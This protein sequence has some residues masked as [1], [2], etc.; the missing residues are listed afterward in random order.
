MNDRRRINIALSLNHKYM[1]YA[2][3]MLT[4]L[5]EN[6]PNSLKLYIYFLYSDLTKEDKLKLEDV[7]KSHGGEAYWLSV[8]VELFLSNL[9]ISTGWSLEIYYRLLLADILPEEI[10]RILYLDVDIIINHSLENLFFTDLEGKLLGA[11]ADV[12]KWAAI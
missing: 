7:V 8:N 9:P 3:V 1:R 2:Y 5:F 6:Q 4:S 11:C 12:N 10:E